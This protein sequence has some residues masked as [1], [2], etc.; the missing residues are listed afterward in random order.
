M[1]IA[2]SSPF[3]IAV[4]IGMRCKEAM[5]YLVSMI[6]SDFYS[7]RLLQYI[8]GDALYYIMSS[9]LCVILKKE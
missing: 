8:L 9:V 1:D 2:L 3:V 4:C 6:L 5:A 7:N